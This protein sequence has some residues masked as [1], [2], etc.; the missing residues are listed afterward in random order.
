[1]RSKERVRWAQLRVGFTSAVALLILGV[2]LYLLT[3]GALFTEKTSLYLYVPDATGVAQGSPVR[4]DGIGVGK[5]GSV[6][7]SGSRDPNR[8]VRLTLRIERES[9]AMIPT[10]SYAE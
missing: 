3:G 7:L 2:L 5:V 9:L 4:V 6:S 10:A 8:V 1:M